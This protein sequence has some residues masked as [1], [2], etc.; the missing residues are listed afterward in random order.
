MSYCDLFDKKMI[1]GDKGYERCKKC[2]KATDE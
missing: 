2:M 1:Y